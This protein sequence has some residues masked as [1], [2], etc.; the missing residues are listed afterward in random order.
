MRWQDQGIVIAIRKYGDDQIIISIF[1][2]KHGLK[3]GLAKYSKKATHRLQIGDYVNV[4]W[5]SRLIS[6]LGCFKYELIKST[7]Y[8]YI[9]DNL[10]TMCIAFS[11]VILDQVLPEN[12]ENYI[13]YNCLDI[14]IN[15]IQFQDI[16]WKI[17]YLRLELTLLSEL[18]FGLDLSRCAVNN[19]NE[20]LT[21]ISPK[22]GKAVSKT[23]GLPYSKS[24]LPLPQLLY[25]VYNNY[26]YKYSKT[27]FKLSLNVLGYFFKKHFLTEKNT[28]LIKYREE[29]IKLIDLRD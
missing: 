8:H 23:V 9:Q 29:I 28:I 6:N 26:E 7:L 17:K 18:G 15:S 20:N 13:I 22:T 14:F 1:T 21:F 27:D 24:L 4:T 2:Q 19:T 16:N 10:K 5:S 3:K 11:T 25:D 12:E